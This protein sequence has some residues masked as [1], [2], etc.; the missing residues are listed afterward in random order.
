[1]KTAEKPERFILTVVGV[2]GGGLSDSGR[3]YVASDR[4]ERMF[5]E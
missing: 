4:V 3:G 1:M 2:A 5:L